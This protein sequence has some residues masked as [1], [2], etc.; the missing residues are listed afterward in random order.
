MCYRLQKRSNHFLCLLILRNSLGNISK[1]F[2]IMYIPGEKLR[3]LQLK[4]GL[5]YTL[6]LKPHLN[7]MSMLINQ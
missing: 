7:K 5:L 2:D 6:K 4:T 1:C 3:E